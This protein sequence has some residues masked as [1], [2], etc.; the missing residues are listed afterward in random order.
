M[1]YKD[2]FIKNFI[3]RRI[4]LSQIDKDKNGLIDVVNKIVNE[5]FKWF[6][7]EICVF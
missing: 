2:I 5:V 4:Y 7:E 6:I 1:K 3:S